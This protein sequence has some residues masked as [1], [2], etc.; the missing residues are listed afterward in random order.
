MEL[1]CKE[2]GRKEEL[3]KVRKWCDFEAEA[4]LEEN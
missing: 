2:I 1:G 3:E 4:R